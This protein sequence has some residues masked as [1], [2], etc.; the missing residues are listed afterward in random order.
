MEVNLSKKDIIHL[1]RGVE[2]PD[3]KTLFEVKEIW[4]LGD[5]TGGFVDSF[6]WHG[7]NSTSWDKYSEIDLYGLYRK[8][9]KD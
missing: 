4:G 8:L 1:L 7:T 5:Y 2:I 3:Y 6:E 9:T